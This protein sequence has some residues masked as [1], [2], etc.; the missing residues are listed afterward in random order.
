MEKFIGTIQ[1]MCG[2]GY[3]VKNRTLSRNEIDMNKMTTYFAKFFEYILIKEDDI[4]DVGDA[5]IEEIVK[6]RE[7]HSEKIEQYVKTCA[8]IKWY[9]YFGNGTFNM[10]LEYDDA[11]NRTVLKNDWHCFLHLNF[12]YYLINTNKNCILYEYVIC[13]SEDNCDFYH[14]SD[15]VNTL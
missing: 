15:F 5:P 10:G 13:C 7:K 8:L 1:K 14:Y 2:N 9:N 12:T 11:D 4:E 3:I 6:I